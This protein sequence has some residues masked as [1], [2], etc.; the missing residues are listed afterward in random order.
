M[1]VEDMVK[2]PGNKVEFQFVIA[3]SDMDELSLPGALQG[4][5]SA[6]LDHV[7]IVKLEIVLGY[8]YFG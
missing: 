4:I 2:L 1:V 7:L 8:H 3:K 6:E 5:I